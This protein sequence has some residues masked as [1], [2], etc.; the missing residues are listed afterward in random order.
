MKT[1]YRGWSRRLAVGMLVAAAVLLSTVSA[2]A[3]LIGFVNSPA[4]NSLDWASA[5]TG[6]GGTINSNVD[7][8]GHGLGAL[9]RGSARGD[10][11]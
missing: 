6:A 5:I 8:E 3:A 4:S 1:K 11:L 9:D 10:S 2:N 7:F